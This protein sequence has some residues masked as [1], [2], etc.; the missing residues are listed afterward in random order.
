[1]KV[2]IVYY[3]QSGTTQKMA[4]IINDGLKKHDLA[5]TLS[6]V[7]KVKPNDLLEFDG[8]II[9]SPTYYGTIVYQI[10]KLL[11][12]SVSFH[13]E[14]NGKVG[15]AFASSAN[16]AGGNETTLLSILEAMLI[17]GMIVQGDP[18]G[19]HYGPV[20]VGRVDERAEVNCA[21]FAQ[22]FAALLKKTAGEKTR[23]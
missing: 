11:D 5:V 14:L 23:V 7:D 18:K 13:G 22:R 10:K 2:L 15:G 17:H 16:V 19:D 20:A 1:M 9:G 4:E 8:I 12:E 3:S 21:R 6:A